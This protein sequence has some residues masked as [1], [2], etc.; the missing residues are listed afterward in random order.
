M[1]ENSKEG[2]HTSRSLFRSRDYSKGLA[3]SKDVVNKT[4]YISQDEGD[5]YIAGIVL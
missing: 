2:Y 1:L 3:C 5:L 4:S